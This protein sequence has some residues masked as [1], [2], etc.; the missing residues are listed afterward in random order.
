[1]NKKNQ[2]EKP[3]IVSF[4]DKLYD[5][6]TISELEQR[7]E[8]SETWL[9]GAYVDCPNLECGVNTPGGG[10]PIGPPEETKT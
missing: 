3:E 6:F 7:L 9:C 2:L 5:D 8:T 10:G 1:M 4:N